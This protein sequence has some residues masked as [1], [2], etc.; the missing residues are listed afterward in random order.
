MRAINSI[1]TSII[2]L[3]AVT[4]SPCFAQ[5]QVSDDTKTVEQLYPNLAAGILTYA[6]A[7]ILQDSVLLKTADIQIVQ[8]DIDAVIAKQPPQF[9][10]ELRQNAFFVLEQEAAGK[11]LKK[12]AKESLT[13]QSK[14]VNS[15]DDNQLVNTFFE[16]ITKDINVA[17][18][19]IEKFYKENESIFCGTP[20]EK[21]RGQIV[22][23]V[24]QDK[25]QRFVD[26]YVSKL[27]QKID[28]TIAEDWTKTQAQAA[29]DNVLDKSRANGKPTLAVFS[30]KSCCGPDKMLPVI[31]TIRAKYN[32]KVNIVYIEP[33]KEQILSAR[34][35]IRSIPA[36]VF[37][38]AKGKE[39]FRHSGFFSDTDIVA[40]L[41]EI[42][43]K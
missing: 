19:D 3:A 22:S 36:Q 15:V 41:T 34:Y 18:G 7:G 28:I 16:D 38:D 20:L 25:K 30:A 2:F 24:L 29:K 5:Q 4:I 12:L 35:G 11:L 8:S 43:V 27:G 13:S 17:D 37:Y 9:Q 31:D 33:Q 23:F 32:D 42:G 26:D 14:D 1:L 39:F 40:K 21:V 6:K 10:Q